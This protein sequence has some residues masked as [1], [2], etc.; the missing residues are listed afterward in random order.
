MCDS[1]YGKGDHA[2]SARSL[3]QDD[4]FKFSGYNVDSQYSNRYGEKHTYAKESDGIYID[5]VK[6]DLT[7]FSYYDKSLGQY[8]DLDIENSPVTIAS[9]LSKG[10]FSAAESSP[11]GIL[12]P[13]LSSDNYSCLM[14]F[15]N[16]YNELS[17]NLSAVRLYIGYFNFHWYAGNYINMGPDAGPSYYDDGVNSIH[18]TYNPV[19]IR[20]V[21]TIKSGITV[22]KNTTNDGSTLAKACTISE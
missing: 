22:T 8:V 4:I 10:C 15:A 17:E 5:G 18:G 20:P 9:N 14:A 3:N 7:N 13:Q 6:S 19:T 16:V 1:L 2:K 21:V 12:D 11:V